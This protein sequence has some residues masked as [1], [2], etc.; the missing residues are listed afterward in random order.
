MFWF[1]IIVKFLHFFLPRD[2][3]A[4]ACKATN[5]PLPSV[6]T[7]RKLCRCPRARHST[8][9]FL[10]NIRSFFSP[11][12]RDFPVTLKSTFAGHRHRLPS[13]SPPGIRLARRRGFSEFTRESGRPGIEYICRL[14][15]ETLEIMIGR[16]IFKRP[17]G[18]RCR[19]G[20][21]FS[22]ARGGYANARGLYFYQFFF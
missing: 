4:P 12:S 21:I 22:R 14:R 7:R 13:P 20:F 6:T 15:K 3:K 9:T 17:K 5:S 11:L 10:I 19:V 1:K 18:P 8:G 16:E 2:L